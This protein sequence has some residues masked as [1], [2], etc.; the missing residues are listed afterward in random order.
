MSYQIVTTYEEACQAV[1]Q[2]GIMPL[3]NL[4]PDHPSLEAIT[5]PAAWHTGAETDPWRW[6]N[7][8][9]TEGV[10]A[11]GRFIGSKPLLISC[12]I[13]PL[14]SR[15]LARDRTI[16]ECYKAGT[17]A[18]AAIQLY[19]IIQ[20][21]EI[22]DV[23]AL[24]RQ[25]GMQDKTE[26]TA[27]DHAL[28]DLQNAA[29]IV[30]SGTASNRNAEGASSGWDGTCYMLANTWLIQ[31]HITPSRLTSADARPQLFAWL[32]PRCEERALAFL[33]KKLK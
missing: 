8:F 29:S 1:A 18:R 26:K 6:R 14:M 25:A 15:L 10:A 21:H 13:F 24:R 3:S 19:E 31:H 17:L 32:A 5:R 23:R 4:I 11:Y 12:E 9:A 33:Q 28:I 20:Q 7:R 27:F 2:L 16:E 30:M 22:I